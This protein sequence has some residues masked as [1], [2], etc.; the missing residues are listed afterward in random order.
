MTP[1]PLDLSYHAISDEWR[2]AGAVTP[3]ALEL[4][5]TDSFA[6]ASARSQPAR[7]SSGAERLSTSRSRPRHA[8]AQK[9]T[10]GWETIAHAR[11]AVGRSVPPE[12]PDLDCSRL[13]DRMP[14]RVTAATLRRGPHPRPL[15]E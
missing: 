10:R 2:H 1:R 14:G 9:A 7:S 6:T 15:G 8:P 11:F 13:R 5:L 4:H 3:R 12:R